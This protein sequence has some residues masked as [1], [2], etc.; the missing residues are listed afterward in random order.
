MPRWE[1]P[2]WRQGSICEKASLVEINVLPDNIK[3][4][5]YQV[6]IAVSHDC[7]ITNGDEAKEPYI[8]FFPAKIL[9]E[10][11]GG[12]LYGKNP[13]KLQLQILKST[14]PCFME[15]EAHNRLFLKKESL[16]SIYPNENY[17]MYK[18]GKKILQDWLAARYRRH[19]FPDKLMD[20]LENEKFWQILTKKP[21]AQ[22]AECIQQYR[23]HYEP[24]GDIECGEKYELQVLIIH[25]GSNEARN[26]AERIALDLKKSSY[27]IRNIDLS[28]CEARST[29]EVTMEDLGYYEKLTLDYISHRFDHSDDVK[30][31]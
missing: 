9:Q 10:C 27:A 31:F 2:K 13:R 19:A 4:S 16:L 26:Y 11:N 25:D 15:L 18:D 7:D 23:I 14:V 1:N 21:S 30:D 8:E 28:Y 20:I 6:L 5:D 29:S 12:Y 24:D 17:A 3:K 22:I